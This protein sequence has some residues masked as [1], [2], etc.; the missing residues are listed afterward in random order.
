MD[1]S[2]TVNKSMWKNEK[3]NLIPLPSSPATVIKDKI[4]LCDAVKAAFCCFTPDV[5]KGRTIR[6]CLCCTHWTVMALAGATGAAATIPAVKAAEVI[7]VFA[8]T[9][10]VCEC[11]VCYVAMN[12]NSKK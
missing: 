11:C 2:S 3:I 9:G 4:S 5:E 8:L 7:S 1:P 10:F 12:R 6:N